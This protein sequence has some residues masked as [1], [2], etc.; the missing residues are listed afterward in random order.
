MMNERGEPVDEAG[1]SVPVE[2][3]GLNA[4]PEAGDDFSA[5]ADERRARELAEFR[6]DQSQARRNVKQAANIESIFA[7][8]AQGEKRVLRLVLKADVRGSLEAIS[9]ACAKLG[10]NEVAVTIIRAGVGGI[11]ES[12]A[13]LALTSDAAIFGFNVRADN[14]AKAVIEREGIDL[15]YYSVIYELLDD[16][17]GIL[18]DLLVPEIREE[19]VGT[20]EV[21]D[22]FP[23]PRFGRVAGCMVVDGTVARNKQIR[24]LRDNVV[25]FEGELDS[26]R[27]F[28]DDV[29]EVRS[30]L[31][32][33]IGVRNYNDVRVGDKIEVFESGEVART[34]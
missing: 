34:L 33:G 12:D 19:I 23:A 26:L 13:M 32:C 15:H 16:V 10:N 1:P 5:V 20:A 11:T 17:R 25:I 3:L 30:G 29:A 27:R 18:E 8:L 6:A 28:Q 9:Q 24:V 21:R 31:E 14:N 4:T 2:I 7:D 22:V